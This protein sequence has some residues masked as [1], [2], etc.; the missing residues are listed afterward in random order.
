M[1]FI[2]DETNVAIVR[3]LLKA[4]VRPAPPEETGKEADRFAGQT[5]VF[6]GALKRFTREE[7]Q[8]MVERLGGRASSSVTLMSLNSNCPPPGTSHCKPM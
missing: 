7:A 2:Q 4:G 5:F 1:R 8:A 6:T 3:E